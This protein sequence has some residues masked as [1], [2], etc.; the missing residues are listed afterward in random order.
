MLDQHALV[1]RRLGP[2]ARQQVLVLLVLAQARRVGAHDAH[3]HRREELALET[4]LR[5]GFTDDGALQV[6][7]LAVD[8]LKESEERGAV[9]ELRIDAFFQHAEELVEGTVQGLMRA[10]RQGG[11]EK[12]GEE[13]S[14]RGGEASGTILEHAKAREK[15]VDVGEG[16]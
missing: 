2:H 1:G 3:P 15:G 8:G 11:A 10:L 6:E 16:G 9:G 14:K 5:V 7:E 4:L 12:V 13:S